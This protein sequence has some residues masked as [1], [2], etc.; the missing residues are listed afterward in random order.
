MLFFD[1]FAGMN[2]GLVEGR[3]FCHSEQSEESFSRLGRLKGKLACR[4]KAFA[5]KGFLINHWH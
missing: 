4:G 2:E 1:F 3:H 5:D